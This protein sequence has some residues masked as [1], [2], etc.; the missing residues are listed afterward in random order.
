[1]QSIRTIPDE[2]KVPSTANFQLELP[3]KK[4]LNLHDNLLYSEKLHLF[5]MLPKFYTVQSDL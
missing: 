2:K 4:V 1:M 3:I 5:R